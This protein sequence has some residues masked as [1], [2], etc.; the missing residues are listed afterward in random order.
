MHLIQVPGREVQAAMCGEY[1]TWLGV[2]SVTQ[3][4][5]FIYSIGPSNHLFLALAVPPLYHFVSRHTGFSWRPFILSSRHSVETG[6]RF[7][8]AR[9]LVECGIPYC[10]E[11]KKRNCGWSSG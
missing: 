6:E 11:D 10:R 5:L 3:P 4:L 7:I 2:H 1:Y 8:R 9:Y